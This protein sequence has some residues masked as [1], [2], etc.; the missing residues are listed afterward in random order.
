MDLVKFENHSV[1]RSKNVRLF[2]SDD[3]KKAIL[4]RNDVRNKTH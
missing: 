4:R 2:V 1:R 3:N